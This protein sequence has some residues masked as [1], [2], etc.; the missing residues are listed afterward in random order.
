MFDTI[1]IATSLVLA[2]PEI[3]A[4]GLECLLRLLYSF[5]LRPAKRA[6]PQPRQSKRPTPRKSAPK[7][8]RQPARRRRKP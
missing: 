1:L 2:K 5:S 3:L 4:G 6:P 8:P 7:A